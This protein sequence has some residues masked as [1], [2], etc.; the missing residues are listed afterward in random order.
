MYNTES[1]VQYP[2]VNHNG[3]EY[4]ILQQDQILKRDCVCVY[5]YT[6]ICIIESFCCTAVFK[7]IVKKTL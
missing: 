2:M 1:Y 7:N 5:I 4:F 3:K 6:H